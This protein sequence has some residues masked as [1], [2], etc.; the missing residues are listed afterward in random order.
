MRP[1]VPAERLR[2]AMG[3]FAT[4]VTVI[5]TRDEA[6]RRLGT[7]ANAVASVSLRPPL[8]LACLRDESETLAALLERRRFAINVLH[9]SQSDLS[10][11]FARRS[12]ADSWDAV[13]HRTSH[14]VPVLEGALATL[15]CELHDVADGGDHSV[16]I[17]RVVELEH[18]AGPEADPLLFYGGGYR[19]LGAPAPPAP[20]PAP[21]TEVALPSRHGPL[22]MFSLSDDA[23]ATSVA[24]VTGHPHGRTG[25]LVYP[26]PACT[27]GDAL[28]SV[29]CP[30]HGRLER[31]LGTMRSE[32]HGVAVYHRDRHGGFS[33]CC[34]S[35]T[36]GGAAVGPVLS[37]DAVAAL[38]RAVALLE[39]RAVRLIASPEDG[40][41]A[42]RA[43][44]PIGE[45]VES[46]PIRIGA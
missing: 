13:A 10:E 44:V 39:L 23:G 14:G 1:D 18:S 30:S 32:G 40:S 17:G 5:T 38:A 2:A 45:L 15:E 7:T 12:A 19:A 35:P 27:L 36:G 22:R 26:H 4:G 24:A 42:A 31:V 28:G 11:R 43:G 41:R 33:T 9:T 46:A 29:A 16:V 20:R 8:V 21:P 34:T 25:V 3:R 37:D 6:G